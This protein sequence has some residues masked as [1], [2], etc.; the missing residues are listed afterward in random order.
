MSTVRFI[1]DLH[2]GHENM[3]KKRGFATA[4]EHDEYII[5]MWN[6]VVHK[7]DLTYILGDVTMESS[8]PYP[9]LDRLNGRKK[10]VLGN[11]DLPKHVPDLLKHVDQV[12]ALMRYKGIWM[13]HCPIHPM[14]LDY[15]VQRIIHGHIHEK[16]VERWFTLF[17]FRMFKRIDRRYHCV[18]CEHVNY[19]PVTLAQ[20]GIER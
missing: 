13:S 1:A 3:A 12:G 7:R 2:L 18:S 9:M 5:K 4:E 20:L 6:S 8:K 10:V 17:G 15:R 16:Y 14:E 11:H 19:K